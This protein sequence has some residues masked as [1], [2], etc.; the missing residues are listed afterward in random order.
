MLKRDVPALMLL[1]LLMSAGVATESLTLQPAGW[2][3]AS[4]CPRPAT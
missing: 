2:A 4:N 3:E 1:T